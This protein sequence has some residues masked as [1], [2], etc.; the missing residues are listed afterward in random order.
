[1]YRRTTYDCGQV[2]DVQCY[3]PGNYGAPGKKRGKKQ[4]RTPEDIARQNQTNRVLKVKRLIR[5]NFRKGDW[6]LTLNYRKGERPEMIEEAKS[7]LTKFLGAIRKELK[8]QDMT[9]RYIGVTEIG[10]KGQA[11]HHHL[12][13]ED[14][15]IGGK[16]IVELVK[17][18]WTYGNTFWSAMYEE[19][20]FEQLAS[21]I[22]KRETK[23]GSWGTYT[24]SRGNLKEPVKKTKMIH[25]KRWPEIPKKK[26]YEL[27]KDSLYNGFN[28][29]TGYPYQHYSMRKIQ[30][31][32]R[33]ERNDIYRDYDTRS[34]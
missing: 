25:H 28:P 15:T 12:I 22:V 13:I 34:G 16:S 3:Y 4:K 7:N 30:A 32:G 29:V 19:G 26:G 10:K 5:C 18:T 11:L 20:D 33:D 1:M 6:H 27:I 17:T 2:I 21:Y 24:R 31:G 23:V 14:L 8:K 9:F